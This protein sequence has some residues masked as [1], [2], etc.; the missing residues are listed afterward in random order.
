MSSL[1]KLSGVG[2]FGGEAYT[3]PLDHGTHHQ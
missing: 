3:I 2:P 1:H